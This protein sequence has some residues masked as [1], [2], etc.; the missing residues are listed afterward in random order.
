MINVIIPAVVLVGVGVL[1]YL[2]DR[3]DRRNGRK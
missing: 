1:V 2:F 3:N